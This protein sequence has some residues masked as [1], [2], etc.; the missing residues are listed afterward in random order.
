MN[1]VAATPMPV[2]SQRCQPEAARRQQEESAPKS[3]DHEEAQE[4][5]QTQAEREADGTEHGH[6]GGGGTRG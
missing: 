5:L 6:V 1:S 3:S 4:I 2:N